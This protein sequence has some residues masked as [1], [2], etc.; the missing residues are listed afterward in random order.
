[1]ALLDS[2]TSRDIVGGDIAF[3]ISYFFFFF[4]LSAFV[5][6]RMASIGLQPF[7]TGDDDQR[8]LCKRL[9]VDC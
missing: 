9:S 1:M 5:G 8:R 2:P 6:G 3:G 4:F 7:D